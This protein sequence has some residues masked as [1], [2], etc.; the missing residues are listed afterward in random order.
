MNIL[1]WIAVLPALV[2]I[3]YI[4]RKDKIEKEP[5]SLLVRLFL[6]GAL[7]TVTAM[8]FGQLLDYPLHAFFEEGTLAYLLV[9]NFLVV[10]LVE[11]GGKF[12]FLKKFSWK[13]PAFNYTFDAIVYGVVTA[14]GFAAVENV[15]YVYE[16]GLGVAVMRALLSVP[17]HAI[18]GVFMGIF[19]GAAK[20]CQI[21][22][23]KAGCGRNLRLA[24]II[25][26]IM[27][28][29]YDFSLSSGSDLAFVGFLIYEVVI[30]VL[31]IVLINKNS[32]NDQLLT[33]P[34]TMDAPGMLPAGPP[35][36]AMPA[37]Q[38]RNLP[39]RQ[40]L[41]SQNSPELPNEAPSFEVDG[42][43]RNKTGGFE[44]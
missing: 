31:A 28:G 1:F 2:L 40:N 21:R 25:P 42:N 6:G 19:Y 13:N 14:L 7:S 5:I 4:Y 32:K 12:F 23:D 15:P 36:E 17:G 33:A 16:G 41:P 35:P 9:E 8:I 30:T 10:A 44:A 37:L 20:R 22:Y 34:V 3:A 26:T 39:R 38:K 43:D 27:H 24:L 18:D 29:F 11:E